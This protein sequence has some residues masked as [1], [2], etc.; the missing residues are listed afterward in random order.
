MRRF[1]MMWLMAFFFLGA[2]GLSLAADDAP[3]DLQ[4][5]EDVVVEDKAGRPASNR[6]PKAP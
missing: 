3:K 6:Y 2:G 4:Q 1:G 5:L